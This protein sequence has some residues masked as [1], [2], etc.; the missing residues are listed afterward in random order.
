MNVK[1]MNKHFNDLKTT[2][3]SIERADQI[4]LRK[5]EIMWTRNK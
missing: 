5:A 4:F 2:Q 3:I 1:Q